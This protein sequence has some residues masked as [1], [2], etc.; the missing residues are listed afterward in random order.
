MSSEVASVKYSEGISQSVAVPPEAWLVISIILIPE[1]LTL[2][3][4]KSIF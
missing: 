2:A 3:P 4:V 1:T